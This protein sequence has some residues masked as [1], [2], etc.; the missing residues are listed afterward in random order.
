MARQRV[1]DEWLERIKAVEREF[2]VAQ[3]AVEDFWT[4]LNSGITELPAKTKARDAQATSDHLEGTYLI[5]L[6]AAF[7]SGLRSY[8]A[9]LNR[10]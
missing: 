9:T 5:R 1:R 7:E 3:T 6:F 2:L 4:A 8:Y 10:K